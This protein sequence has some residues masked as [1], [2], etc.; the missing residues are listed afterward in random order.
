MDPK[1]C[2]IKECEN[3]VL[4]LGLCDKHWKRN[5]KF[6]S[7]IAVARHSGSFRGLSAETRFFMQ[8]KKTDTCW[9]WIGARDAHGYGVFKG[10]V[11]GVLFKRAH[12]FS[13]AFHTGDLL[14]GTQ[15]LHSCDNPC[16]VNP[17]HLRAGTCAENMAEKIAK[18]R[19]R[20]PQGTRNRAA[21]LTDEQAAAILA[22]PRPY[23][24]IAADYGVAAATIGS[25]KQRHSWRH[26][27]GEVVRH[28]RVGK[29]GETCYAAKL[30]AEDVL[31]IRASS[32]PGKDLALKY[33]V[34]PQSITDIRK[35]RSWSHI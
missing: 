34:S 21:I 16:C 15:A 28:K 27:A 19:A 5:R 30:T 22:D 10:E 14:V 31:A 20:A 35:R 2:C 9:E 25:L 23:A 7:P 18:G 13:L 29:Q 12:R 17:A 8:V 4:A 11:G 3:V 33:G 24:A 1:I 26:I 32:E 6:G